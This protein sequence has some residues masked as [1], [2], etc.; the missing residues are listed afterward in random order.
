MQYSDVV[1]ALGYYCQQY[2]SP[3]AEW[4]ASLPT[5]LNNAELRVY[6]DLDF[7]ATRGENATVSFTAGSRTLSMAPMTG[8]PLSSGDRLF[9][10]YPV[11]V[12][13][14]SAIVPQGDAPQAGTRVRFILTS[15]DFIDV[16]WPEEATTQAPS[17]AL[18]YYALLDHQTIIVAPTPDKAYTAEITGTWRPAPLSSTNPST[19]L[20]SNL[21]DLAFKAAMVEAAGWMRDFGQQSDDPKM[22]QSWEALYQEAKANAME[23]ESRRKGQDPGWQPFSPTPLSGTPRH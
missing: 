21:P 9:N 16:V 8:N 14:V 22:A 18:A 12:Q 2:I 1:N 23:E 11:V 6:R 20:W 5:I 4:T 15:V 10:S 13:G 3:S 7:L 17:T 19:W